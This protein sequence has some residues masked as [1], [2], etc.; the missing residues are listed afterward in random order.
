MQLFPLRS[1]T[2]RCFQLVRQIKPTGRPIDRGLFGLSISEGAISNILARVRQ[3]LL[4]ATAT[5]ETVKS[6]IFE[7]PR[8]AYAARTIHH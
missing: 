2:P 7:S 8:A 4:D 3:L 6:Q 1:L 5:I